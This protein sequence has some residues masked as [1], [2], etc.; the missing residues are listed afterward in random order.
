MNLSL[1]YLRRL[2]LPALAA[3]SLSLGAAPQGSEEASRVIEQVFSASPGEM[4]QIVNYHGDV[5]V[6]TAPGS[7]A[8]IKIVL[9]ASGSSLEQAQQRLETVSV[10]E[11][12]GSGSRSWTTTIEG[13]LSPWLAQA[14]GIR[15]D[16]EISVPSEQALRIE[17]RHGALE[18]QPRAGA[19][20][21]SLRSA[22]LRAA[23]LEGE[24]QL[25]MDASQG[26]IEHLSQGKLNLQGARLRLES[27]GSLDL[28]SRASRVELMRGEQVALDAQLGELYFRDLAQIRGQYEAASC[29][30]G[31]LRHSGNLQVRYAPPLEIAELA[32]GF[33]SLRLE[34][35][36]TAFHLG[37]SPGTGY[38][39]TARL[40]RGDLDLGDSEQEIRLTQRE[41][42][43][44][45][46]FQTSNQSQ[47]RKSGGSGLISIEGQRS[48]VRLRNLTEQEP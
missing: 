23:R 17:I 35:K 46:V 20:D 8:S 12:S 37:I 44:E 38:E 14:Q 28:Y 43:N 36:I 41:S 33:D 3:A 7:S 1:P 25:D 31:K 27:A 6:L 29:A 21:L 5:R 18:I 30:I 40:Q 13:A 47:A 4:L 11:A 26:E 32:P 48:N 15:A 34:G 19:L 45:R 22:K 16:Y 2:L 9:T 39:M 10:S 42:E 24:V